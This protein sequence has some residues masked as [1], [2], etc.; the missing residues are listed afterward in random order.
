MQKILILH[1]EPTERAA[2]EDYYVNKHLPMAAELPSLNAARYSIGVSGI[3]D[4]Y[5]GSPYFA[6]FEG[7]YDSQED[8]ASAVS[9]SAGQ[10]PFADVANFATGGAVVMRYRVE[11]LI[12]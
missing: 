5:T 9:S 3:G 1:P 6:L 12:G 4:P 7:E 8:L 2:F 10:A 11:T